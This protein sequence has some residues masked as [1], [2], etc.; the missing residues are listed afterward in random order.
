M[1]WNDEEDQY[2][3]YDDVQ[4]GAAVADNKPMKQFDESMDMGPPAGP[5][6]LYIKGMKLPQNKDGETVE[7]G[8]DCYLDGEKDY[9]TT[10]TMEVEFA[11]KEDP[12]KTIRDFFVLPPGFGNDP[13]RVKEVEL[14]MKYTSKDVPATKNNTGFNWRKLKNFLGHAGLTVLDDGSIPPFSGRDLRFWPDGSP[15]DIA[16]IIEAPKPDPANPDAK[17]YKSIKLFSYKDSEFTLLRRMNPN[18]VA[19]SS[20]GSA[21]AAATAKLVDEIDVDL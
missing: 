15:R 5:C 19:P 11:W 16:A 20:N 14:Y 13:A 9:F 2:A 10:F 3:K 21:K 17:R 8:F 12:D 4:I 18:S 6:T 1:A 7:K